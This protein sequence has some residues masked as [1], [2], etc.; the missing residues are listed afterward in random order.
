MPSTDDAWRETWPVLVI[1]PGAIGALV[2]G[3]LAMAGHPVVVACRTRATATTIAQ[4]GVIVEGP[5]G[6]RSHARVIAASEP[7]QLDGIEGG[8]PAFRAVVLATKVADAP[9]ALGPWLDV[10]DPSV[11][12]VAMQNGL[13]DPR[14]AAMA[15]DRLVECVVAFPAT[16]G[17]IGESVQTGPGDFIIGYLGA[18]DADELEGV[19]RVLDAVVPTRVSDNVLGAKWTKLLI[20]ACITSLGVVTGGD[21]GGLLRRKE[22]RALFLRIMAEGVEAGRA[23]GIVFESVSGLDP[24]RLAGLS[25]LGAPGRGLQHLVLRV[26]GRKVRRQ[27]S[28]SLQSL[29]RGRRTEVDAL[30]GAIVSAAAAHRKAAPVNGRILDVIHRI[31]RGEAQPDIAHLAYLANGA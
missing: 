19:R 9:G 6:K 21:L 28:S 20:N 4:R 5:D 22:A 23:E 2:A 31:E 12:V 29:E 10:V 7:A 18:G 24:S 25:R 17:G 16:L 3:R 26:L 1:G 15:G 27:R 30:N 14:V 8:V 13:P 11:P